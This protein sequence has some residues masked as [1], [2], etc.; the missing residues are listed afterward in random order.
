MSKSN[1]NQSNGFSEKQRIEKVIE[2]GRQIGEVQQGEK[3][4]KKIKTLA[5]KML[6]EGDGRLMAKY[7]SM[8]IEHTKKS[9]LLDEKINNI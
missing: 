9:N 1:I 5:G 2:L 3:D 8:K 4:L 6:N 7:R